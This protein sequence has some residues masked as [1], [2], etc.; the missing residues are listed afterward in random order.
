MFVPRRRLGHRQPQNWCAPH[1]TQPR[2]PRTAGT[3]VRLHLWGWE[4]RVGG[5][6]DAGSPVSPTNDCV[7][8]CHSNLKSQ[9]P[10]C[11][12]GL[13][14][15]LWLSERS[16][17]SRPL[18]QLLCSAALVP[19]TE[20]R[21]SAKPGAWALNCDQRVGQLPVNVG[22]DPPA[23]HPR[24][25]PSAL[26]ARPVDTEKPAPVRQEGC[27]WFPRRPPRPCPAPA[28]GGSRAAVKTAG[29]SSSGRS[30]SR[31]PGGRTPPRS[32]QTLP[33]TPRATSVSPAS[34]GPRPWAA[35]RGSGLS[36]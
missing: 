13:G 17:R 18:G 35:S 2:A 23:P 14:R 34:S 27:V 25:S 30:A 5:A 21:G 31:G 1:S 7:R 20:G 15:W 24:P 32:S 3:P 9:S 36:R 19:S 12:K 6:R 26:P 29:P 8:A 33:G 11:S 16:P 22:W 28:L 10:L 4:G